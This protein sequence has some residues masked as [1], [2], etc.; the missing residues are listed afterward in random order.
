MDAYFTIH[1]INE[2][3][4]ILP[5]RGLSTALIKDNDNNAIWI[6]NNKLITFYTDSNNSLFSHSNYL[7]FGGLKGGSYT[8]STTIMLI[9]KNSA[10]NPCM[11][12]VSNYNAIEF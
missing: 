10:G 9:G 3:T 11:I 12:R 6:S 4:D 5:F 1:Y 2:L 8:L 7:L